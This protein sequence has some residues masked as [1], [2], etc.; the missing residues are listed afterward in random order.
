MISV[1][2]P[3]GNSESLEEILVYVTDWYQHNRLTMGIG[4]TYDTRTCTSSDNL[5]IGN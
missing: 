2:K 3:V 4:K 5:N 1:V